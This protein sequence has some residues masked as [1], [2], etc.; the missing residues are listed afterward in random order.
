MSDVIF[1]FC[2]HCKT[3]WSADDSEGLARHE[4]HCSRRIPCPYCHAPIG[5]PCTYPSGITSQSDH[6]KRERLARV[7]SQVQDNVGDET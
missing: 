7:G 2:T 6:A 3:A 4:G 5:R 1:L